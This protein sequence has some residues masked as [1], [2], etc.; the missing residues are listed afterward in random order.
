MLNCQRP[1]RVFHLLEGRI[2]RKVRWLK[3]KLAL[4]SHFHRF[5]RKQ[6]TPLFIQLGNAVPCK[7]TAA[8][9]RNIIRYNKVNKKGSVILGKIYSNRKCFVINCYN[10]SHFELEQ[11]K[12]VIEY[13]H[14]IFDLSHIKTKHR[15]EILWYLL[16]KDCTFITG[17]N[18]IR[19]IY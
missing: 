11:Q 8:Q 12:F 13:L 15:F 5:F 14:F 3:L 10:V 19:F 16:A 17:E 2:Q 7:W 6:M 18:F 1:N 4:R 9:H